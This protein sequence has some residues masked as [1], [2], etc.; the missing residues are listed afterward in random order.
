MLVT[1]SGISL[2]QA[3][4]S[5][6]N[7]STYAFTTGN[8]YK[9]I[10]NTYAIDKIYD[11]TTNVIV[12]I[13]G[14]ISGDFITYFAQFSDIN[15]NFN[16]NVY[17][18][19]SGSINTGTGTSIFIQ[20]GL[21]NYYPFDFGITPANYATGLPVNDINVFNG[22][23]VQNSNFKVGTGSMYFNGSSQYATINSSALNFTTN[24]LSF[25]CWFNFTSGGWTRLFDFGN[26]I[27]NDN[28][29]YSP[30]NG[31][32]LYQGGGGG[33]GSTEPGGGGYADGNW[34]H[35]AWTLTYAAAGTAT[36]TWKLYID[37]TIVYTS[38]SAGYP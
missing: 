27:A 38:T 20:D 6:Y 37:G 7:I 12:T 11:Q 18:A 35:F 21:V 8:I 24:G 2:Y 14:T 3:S 15:S 1:I 25:V 17:V 32:S 28:I 13:S 19:L 33:V 36:S 29:L 16:K 30:G 22:A 34:H 26:G 31:M 9:K 4:S 23:T 5:N 10:L